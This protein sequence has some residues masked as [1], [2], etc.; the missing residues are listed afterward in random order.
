M[1]RI[2]WLAFLLFVAAFPGSG[3]AD[4]VMDWNDTA[5][6]MMKSDGN[7]QVNH[8]NP[9][10]STRSFAM[11]N[12]AIYD[13][14]QSLNRTHTPFMYTQKWTNASL[15]AAVHTAA[16]DILAECY[17]HTDET[18][19][20]NAIYQSRMASIV[21][22][23]DRIA[24]GVAL[25]QAIAHEYKVNRDSDGLKE[26]SNYVEKSGPGKWRS[27]PWNPG[28]IAWGPQW[29]SVSTFAIGDTTPY[30]D[31][32]PPLPALNS[33][34]YT[35]AYNEVLNYGA[36]DVYGPNDTMTSRTADQ[37][38]IGIFWAYDRR[39]M[40]PPP[41]LFNRH[42]AE[43]ATAIGNTPEQ[44]ARLFAMVSIAQADASVAAWD[45]KFKYDF[46]RPVAGI[47]EADTDGNDDTVRDP[48]WRPLG[49]QGSDPNGF[50]DDFTPPF[51]AW[52]SGHATMG[53]A[54]FKSLG[55]FY[56]TNIFEEADSA[57]G[58]DAVTQSYDLTSEE[59]GGGGMRS[60]S[61][62]S[63]DPLF[64]LENPSDSPD[65]ENAASRIFLGV[66]WLMDQRDGVTL[67][68]MIASDVFSARFAAVPE[69]ATCA[70]SALAAMAM[71]L[72]RRP[73]K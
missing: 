8:A 24:A 36:L 33:P 43:I 32:L 26:G 68:Q 60:F 52:T 45:A 40:G 42:V 3:R 62:F 29:G 22:T 53:A 46:W 21:D 59:E 30:I 18:N 35:A 28:Q 16:R 61:L 67:G 47:H 69:P 56:G 58:V 71:L 14:F 25:G 6:A 48:D 54:V 27:D 11:M 34:E 31:A 13:A 17:D 4:L 19:M 64:S 7:H 70:I 55:L 10:W 73:R 23:P 20:V 50:V 9:G 63:H 39:T 37:T 2:N 5:R 66:H 65:W 57:Y 15:D 41:V 1:M 72:V 38:K 51:P 44:N 12:G 49:A